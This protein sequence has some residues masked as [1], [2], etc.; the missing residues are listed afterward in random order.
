MATN[1]ALVQE[2][3]D[4]RN[5]VEWLDDERRK[6]SRKVAE[7][8]QNLEL[9]L[10]EVQGREQRIQEME[11]RLSSAGAQLG[12]I[13]QFDSQI[14]QFKD[15]IVAMIEQYDQRRVRSENEID[16]LRRVE[17]EGVARELADVRKELPAIARL[18]N[19]L[20]LRIA[21]ETRLA[22]LLGEHQ[23]QISSLRN[24]VDNGER[25][26]AYVEEKEKQ[27]SRTIGEMKT[28]HLESA[29]RWEHFRD[30]L[31]VLSSR[32][33][34]YESSQQSL[35][36]EQTKSRETMKGWLEQIQLGEYER[37]QRI[38]KWERELAQRE[39]V[40]ETYAKEWAV[41][42]DQ[43]NEAKLAV[44]TLTDWQEQIEKQQ[45]E[46]GE[47]LRLEAQRLQARWEAY[48][49]D[50]ENKLKN[51]LIEDEQRWSTV[52]RRERQVQE[53]LSTLDE[54]LSSLEQHK[55]LLTR[56]QTAQADA[57]KRL[58]LLWMEEV[59]KAVAQNPHRRRQPALV[60]VRE[61]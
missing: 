24:L 58:P 54:S 38:E 35:M 33:V 8:E 57:I 13:S 26:I 28:A 4:L 5:R 61:D 15:E 45:R 34:R 36:E 52:N 50:S 19:D 49:Q 39:D 30:Q 32:T 44:K 2:I 48:R 37:N 41:Y 23:N 7:L 25:A 16:R 27:N 55:D 10:R 20:E 18:Q 21:E 43:Y 17:H 51:F 29:K 47:L 53:K 59:E 56:I 60:P 22:S 46:A 42:S 14:V 40:L 1:T 31:D 12:R 11:A 6:M 3:R 9:Q